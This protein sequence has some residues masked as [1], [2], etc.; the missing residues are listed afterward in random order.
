M[1]SRFVYMTL[2]ELRNRLYDHTLVIIAL[3]VPVV[4]AIITSFAFARYDNPPPV[5]L[6]I[7]TGSAASSR[8]SVVRTIRDNEVLRQVAIVNVVPSARQ[9]R[10]LVRDGRDGAALVLPARSRIG[11][12]STP[13]LGGVADVLV[14]PQQ[15][16]A[17]EV[18]EA[19][20]Q[21]IGGK[22]WFDHVVLSTVRG[23]VADPSRTLR[24]FVPRNSVTLA[25]VQ[26]SSRALTAATY[27]GSSMA[28]VFLLFVVT[29]MAKSLWAERQNNTLQRLLASGVGRWTIVTGKALAAQ[30]IGMLSMATVWAVSTGAL[31]ADWGDP[32]AIGLLITVTVAAA[33][34][35]SFGLASLARTEAR[36]DGLVAIVT[37]VL[38]LAGG[39][40]V[41]PADLPGSLVW[42]SLATPNGWA[43]HG[44]VDLAT[45]NGGTSVIWPS[46]LA[47][48]SFAAV[49][50]L[51]IATRLRTLVRP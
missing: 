8:N 18:A 35:L 4:F 10:A 17:A 37:F 13:Q 46:V 11:P 9:A 30:L 1:A 32:A 26:A 48:I 16:I 24:G 2:N 22:E 28:I 33:V 15:P 43:L 44:F 40:F 42:L 39:N 25:D 45:S 12:S 29:P 34:A 21:T 50:W 3:A 6:V 14:S 49:V 38:V 5:R 31:H 27:Y 41:A 47:L 36:L 7:T 23:V 51:L 19:V 20:L